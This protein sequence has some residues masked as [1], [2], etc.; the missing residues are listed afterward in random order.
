MICCSEAHLLRSIV[1][2]NLWVSVSGGQIWNF[3]SAV[4]D[5]RSDLNYNGFDWGA[6]AAPFRYGGVGHT[7]LAS[8]AAASG[9]E[10][11]GRRINRTTCFATL[12]VPGPAPVPIPPQLMT[13]NAG[14]NAI[15][16][17]LILPNINDGFAGAAP[18]LG[19]HELGQP[20]PTYGPRPQGQLSAPT[21]LRIA[22]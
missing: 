14:C 19:A 22:G 8:L 18:D 20:L 5:W 1:K 2:N 15:D 12:N 6:S 3:G 11:N 17:G 13:L 4:K 16:A 9:L 21:N 10:T 7:S